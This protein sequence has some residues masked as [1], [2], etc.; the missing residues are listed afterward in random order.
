MFF[1]TENRLTFNTQFHDFA[2]PSEEEDADSW[3]DKVDSSGKKV[4]GGTTLIPAT[5]LLIA[6]IETGQGKTHGRQHGH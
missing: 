2:N 3:F 4:G 5:Y 6:A 1:S